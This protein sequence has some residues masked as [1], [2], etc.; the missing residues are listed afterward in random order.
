MNFKEKLFEKRKLNK[1]VHATFNPNGPGAVRLHLVPTKFSL[2]KSSPNIVVINGKDYIPLNTAWSIL[3]AIFIEEISKYQGLEISEENLNLAVK[4]TVEK[5]RKIYGK[6]IGRHQIKEDLWNI[7]DTVTAIALNKDNVIDLRGQSITD[8]YKTLNA[9]H[10]VDLMISAMEKHGHWN[11]NQKC[12]HCYAAGQAH[13][14]DHELSTE[15]F[16]KVIKEL[17]KNCESQITFTGGEPTMRVDLVELVKTAD[18]FVTRLNTNGILLTKK[19]CNELYEA[20]L[21][22]VQVTLYSH[23]EDIHNNLVGSRTFNKTV[24]GIKNAIEAGLNVSINTPLCKLN[25]DYIELLKFA[26]ELG[27]T[28]VTCS[29][30]IVTGNAKSKESKNTQLSE[31]DLYKTLKDACKFAEENDME[32]DFTSPGW[33]AEEKLLKLNLNPPS[34]GA[35]LTN[36]AI[37]PNGNVVPCQSWLSEGA[38]L[39]NILDTKWSKIWNSPKCKEIRKQ[40]SQTLHICPLRKESK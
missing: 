31:R 23:D 11:C 26:K 40:S 36:M 6:K 21:D 16:K 17:E 24:Q 32:I 12:L 28:Y 37:T 20:S 22:S 29:G 34:C 33:I 14:S 7:I 27:I 9:P 8:F 10:R 39:G 3:L 1:V 5:V 19:L 35:C 4:V 2:V 38:S 13:S 25:K 15:E 18:W 30:L